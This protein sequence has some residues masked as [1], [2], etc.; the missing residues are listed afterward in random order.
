MACFNRVA[1]KLRAPISSTTKGQ[2][3]AYDPL[4]PVGSSAK[5]DDHQQ[6]DSSTIHSHIIF[7]LIHM[8]VAILCV[9][10]DWVDSVLCQQSWPN[11]DIS[12]RSLHGAVQIG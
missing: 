9:I 1:V 10:T 6:T 8:Y 11:H 12:H 4:V 5:Q 2:V 3:K 7:V